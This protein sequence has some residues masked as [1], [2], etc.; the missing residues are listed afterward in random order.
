MPANTIVSKNPS[1]LADRVHRLRAVLTEELTSRELLSEMLPADVARTGTDTVLD[2][3]DWSQFNQWP[4][5]Q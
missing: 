3:S 4:Q 1:D 2:F 5:Y